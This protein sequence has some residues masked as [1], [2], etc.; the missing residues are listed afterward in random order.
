[1]NVVPTEANH[2]PEHRLNIISVLLQDSYL[3]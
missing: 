1:M 3:D 2:N